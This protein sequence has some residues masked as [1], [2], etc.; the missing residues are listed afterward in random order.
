MIKVIGKIFEAW[1]CISLSPIFISYGNGN[2]NNIFFFIEQRTVLGMQNSCINITMTRFFENLWL[3]V[4][5][6]SYGQENIIQIKCMVFILQ[7]LFR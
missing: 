7:N 3:I 4:K 5:D 1:F 2:H 6:I